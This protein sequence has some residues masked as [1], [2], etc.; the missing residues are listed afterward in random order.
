MVIS[1]AELEKEVGRNPIIRAAYG[2]PIESPI[3]RKLDGNFVDAL[4]AEMLSDTAYYLEH[5]GYNSAEDHVARIYWIDQEEKYADFAVFDEIIVETAANTR[6]TDA[7]YYML[8]K[9]LMENCIRSSKLFC[10][11]SLIRSKSQDESVTQHI[12]SVIRGLRTEGLNEQEIVVART[13]AWTHDLGKVIAFKEHEQTHILDSDYAQTHAKVSKQ[14]LDIYFRNVR[15]GSFHLLPK[16]KDQVLNLVQYHHIYELC[17]KE[18]IFPEDFASLVPPDI[19]HILDVLSYADATSVDAYILYA[20]QNLVEAAHIEVAVENFIPEPA[21]KSDSKFNPA[22]P[23]L[24]RLIVDGIERMQKRI[25]DISND[26]LDAARE[27]I[28]KFLNV[29]AELLKIPTIASIHEVLLDLQKNYSFPLLQAA[30][31]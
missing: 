29:I 17:S 15:K 21:T 10:R 2:L 6:M 5:N 24:L 16:L 13:A 18:I 12:L 9:Q 4:I 22:A 25:A 19:K 28:Q 27:L 31:A 20:L 8:S 30:T 3:A 1:L 26:S 11:L 23:I 14:F 7:E